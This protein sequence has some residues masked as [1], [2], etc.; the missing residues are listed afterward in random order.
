[1]SYRQTIDKKTSLFSI[2]NKDAQAAVAK[3][4]AEGKKV[5]WEFSSFTDPGED[6]QQ[7]RVDDVVVPG[8][9]QAGY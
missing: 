7:V 4:V 1:M 9:R 6:W 8:S 2:V 3:A 5:E